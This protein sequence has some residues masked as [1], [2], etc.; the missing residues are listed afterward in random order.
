MIGGERNE[1]RIAKIAEVA[2]SFGKVKATRDTAQHR[3]IIDPMDEAT[4]AL[5][6]TAC[7]EATPLPGG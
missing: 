3:P 7:V 4:V 6:I 2:L 5:C 1:L